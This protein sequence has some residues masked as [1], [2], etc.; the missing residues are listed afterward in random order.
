MMNYTV[1]LPCCEGDTKDESLR[2]HHVAM[3]R[4]GV[5]RMKFQSYGYLDLRL[6]SYKNGCLLW[7]IDCPEDVLPM[8]ILRFNPVIRKLNDFNDL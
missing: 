4:L 1:G 2:L 3:H 7:D 5:K 6:S 8:L